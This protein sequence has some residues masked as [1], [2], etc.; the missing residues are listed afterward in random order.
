MGLSSLGGVCHQSTIDCY[1]GFHS[2]CTP[3]SWH[4]LPGIPRS[5]SLSLSLS[6]SLCL[7]STNAKQNAASSMIGLFFA[8]SYL[9]M[10]KSIYH[11]RKDPELLE[12]S[13]PSARIRINVHN[14]TEIM[15]M[16]VEF[17]QMASFSINRTFP[18]NNTARQVDVFEAT[19]VPKTEDTFIPL[20]VLYIL[21]T[22]LW[23]VVQKIFQ[24]GEKRFPRLYKVYSFILPAFFTGPL[25]MILLGT[26]ITL[27]DCTF[28]TDQAPYLDV[29]NSV[30]CWSGV[31]IFYAFIG[32]VGFGL[33]F[34]IATLTPYHAHSEFLSPNRDIRYVPL[35]IM[36]VQLLKAFLTLVSIFF[37][38][39]QWVTMPVTCVV[40]LILLVI[41][42]LVR[43]S[44]IESINYTRAALYAATMWSSIVS[45]IALAVDDTENLLPTILLLLGW[46]AIIVATLVL[47]RY[48]SL[49]R[50][51]SGAG[52]AKK[53]F[54]PGTSPKKRFSGKGTT[55]TTTDSFKRDSAPPPHNFGK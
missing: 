22:I 55:S 16:A 20:F 38:S 21:G 28:P 32:L 30:E 44:C 7:S 1:R 8:F 3:S 48:T 24:K 12:V 43:P 4:A 49:E 19:T 53:A 54:K 23:I 13:N 34:P 6:L 25:Y 31:H 18:W 40:E 37:S 42:I 9:L 36:T 39:R 5:Y 29:N 17:F 50:K 52:A 33:F 41:T 14:L 2:V 51:V 45:A 35:Y 26:A 15:N 27:L 10:L 11:G 47:T 46:I